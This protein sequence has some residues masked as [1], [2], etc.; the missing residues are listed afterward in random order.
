MNSKYADEKEK[1]GYEL[2]EEFNPS[3]LKLNE[4]S[5]TPK[6]HHSD[7]SGYTTDGRIANLEF[8]IRNINLIIDDDSIAISGCSQNGKTYTG[9][10]LY[11]ETHKAGSLLLDYVYEKRIPLYI[12][13]LQNDYVVIHNLTLLSGRPE[14]TN[15]TIKSTLY[16]SFEIGKREE[17]K[18][19]DAWI[20][21]KQNNVYKLIYRPC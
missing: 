7:A 1:Q 19:S 9:N 8:K 6:K 16:D 5:Q 21:K 3:T 14:T 4:L 2:F 13:F 11:I 18:L 20:Y 17:L 12:N 10:T 15:R